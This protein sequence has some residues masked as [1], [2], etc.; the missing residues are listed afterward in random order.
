MLNDTYNANPDSV[1][2]ALE[3]L[4]EFQARGNKYVVLGDMLE[5]GPGSP[6]EHKRIGK[7]IGGSRF[8]ELLTFGP[9]AANISQGA[10]KMAKRHFTDKKELADY[11]AGKISAGDVVLVKGSRGMKM[12]QVVTALQERK[13]RA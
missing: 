5:L 13:G 10:G 12:E 7:I 2:S 9:M 4:R 11:L 6:K 3:T 1:L 8:A